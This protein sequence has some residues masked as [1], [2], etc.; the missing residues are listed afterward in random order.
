[1]QT[2]DGCVNG[3][4]TV[5]M[6][7]SGCSTIGIKKELVHADQMLDE[8]CDVIL[9]CRLATSGI[10]HNN[11]FPFNGGKTYVRLDILNT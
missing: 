8:T 5:I 1:M 4:Q 2:C 10:K 6:L 7:D 11:T 3:R 9:E